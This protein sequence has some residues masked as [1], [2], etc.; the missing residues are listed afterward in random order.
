MQPAET[1]VTYYTGGGYL[2]SHPDWH[3]ADAAWKA[4]QV[5]KLLQKN[6]LEPRSVLEIGCGS[7]EI[8]NVL[9]RSMPDYTR[10]TGLEIS[11]QA[12]GMAQ[13][14][15]K[16]RLEFKLGG[17]DD[18]ADVIMYDLILIMDVFEHVEDFYGFLRKARQ[19]GTHFVF[20]IPLDLSVQTVLRAKPLLR[21]RRNA[22]HIHYFTLETA[23]AALADTGFNVR[24]W[25][26]TASYT[27]RPV[28]TFRSRLLNIPR[29]LFFAL[30]KSLTVRILG[31]YSL[32]VYA[33]PSE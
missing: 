18:V 17:T 6:R 8:L 29:R 4:D 30:N 7:G 24:D 5:L 23:L 10:F 14:K 13:A 33:V 22:G 27:D 31:G 9:H 28:R 12:Y 19:S 21:K 26:Y 15:T 11:P 1:L 3:T 20:H 25:H 2:S 16:E 32:L